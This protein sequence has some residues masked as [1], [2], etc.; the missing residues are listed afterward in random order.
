MNVKCIKCSNIVEKKING[1]TVICFKCT[2]NKYQYVYMEKI[3]SIVN[4]MNDNLISCNIKRG[5][6]G[7]VFV[8]KKM[9]IDLGTSP[10]KVKQYDK[11]INFLNTVKEDID[12][13]I[14]YIESLKNGK[15]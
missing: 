8:L 3:L 7:F 13:D 1:R 2:Q 6:G 9:N 5:N 12:K 15:L 10:T 11:Y 14:E 4:P